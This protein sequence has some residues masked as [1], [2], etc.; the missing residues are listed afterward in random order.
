MCKL[1]VSRPQAGCVHVYKL[2][3]HNLQLHVFKLWSRGL[4]YWIFRPV[5]SPAMATT[6]SQMK[7]AVVLGYLQGRPP[8]A[9]KVSATLHGLTVCHLGHNASDVIVIHLT[10]KI[11]SLCPSCQ[12]GISELFQSELLAIS[13][14]FFFVCFTGLF[15][16]LSLLKMKCV[17]VFESC[18]DTTT[19]PCTLHVENG[20]KSKILTFL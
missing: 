8:A 2:L 16:S 18:C 9:T 5:Q 7:H 4:L 6:D 14:A 19:Q 15:I 12:V 11:I 10:H 3:V 1:R 20:I 17:Q 13:T